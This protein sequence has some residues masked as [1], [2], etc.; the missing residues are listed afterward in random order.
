MKSKNMHV[1]ENQLSFMH[2]LE[3]DEATYVA[4]YD[5]SY[6]FCFGKDIAFHMIRDSVYVMAFN[7]SHI[8]QRTEE[9]LWILSD[10]NQDNLCSFTSC[11]LT[12]GLDPFEVRFGILQT[13]KKILNEKVAI[14]QGVKKRKPSQRG[15]DAFLE[16]ELE[17]FARY[18]KAFYYIYPD[19]VHKT[20]GSKH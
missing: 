8:D 13:W 6:E 1:D 20:A 17:G 10:E 5:D 7:R 14:S 16:S 2:I 15:I 4:K 9:L 3:A 11:C 12:A 18:Q 19:Q